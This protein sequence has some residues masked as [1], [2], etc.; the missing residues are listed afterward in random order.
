MEAPKAEAP[1]VEAPK[2]EAPKPAPPVR[3]SASA[4]TECA[5]SGWRLVVGSW[6]LWSL[7]ERCSECVGL[8]SDTPLATVVNSAT[9]SDCLAHCRHGLCEGLSAALGVVQPGG[10]WPTARG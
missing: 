9:C 2:V 1:K 3:M 6:V 8:A 5:P 10:R 7:S 4:V